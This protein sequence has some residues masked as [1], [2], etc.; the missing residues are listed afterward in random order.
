MLDSTTA[1]KLGNLYYTAACEQI[2]IV[3]V[4]VSKYKSLYSS[5]PPICALIKVTPWIH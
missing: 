5:I 1:A 3:T 4:L 2:L